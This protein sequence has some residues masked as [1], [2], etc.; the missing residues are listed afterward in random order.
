VAAEAEGVVGDG[1]DLH[2]AGLVGNVVE[3]AV[4]V[5][6]IVVDGLRH[7]VGLERLAADGHLHRAGGPE[8]VA[9]GAFCGADGEAPGMVPEDGL[10]GL[11][12]ADVAL[13]RGGAVGVDVGNVFGVEAAGGQRGPHGARAAFAAGRWGGHVVGVGGVAVAGDLAVNPRAARLGVLEGLQ[14]DDAGAFAHDEAVAV[15]V[16]WP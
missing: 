6:G 10:D 15:G 12:L 2:F 13:R 16:E 7:D 14:Y 9:G 3:V 1:V 11:C 4:G 8:H 5:G